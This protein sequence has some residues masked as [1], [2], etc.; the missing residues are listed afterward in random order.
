MYSN[1]IL[2]LDL[3]VIIIQKYCEKYLK[4]DKDIDKINKSKTI[5]FVLDQLSDIRKTKDFKVLKYIFTIEKKQKIKDLKDWLNILC[6]NKLGLFSKHFN[7]DVEIDMTKGYRTYVNLLSKL[8]NNKTKVD[9]KEPNK[10]ISILFNLLFYD[11][12]VGGGVEIPKR[13]RKRKK[14]IYTSFKSTQQQQITQQQKKYLKSTSTGKGRWWRIVREQIINP[15]IEE[16]YGTEIARD[17]GMFPHVIN[18]LFEYKVSWLNPEQFRQSLERPSPRPYNKIFPIV[19]QSHI[20]SCW[21]NAILVALMY[22][23]HLKREFAN[24]ITFLLEEGIKELKQVRTQQKIKEASV[25]RIIQTRLYELLVLQ[26]DS[27]STMTEKKCITSDFSFVRDFI[28]ILTA[29][30]PDIFK[31]F[32]QYEKHKANT[33]L[34]KIILEEGGKIIDI[35]NL[36]HILLEYGFKFKLKSIPGHFIQLYEK[37]VHG[38]KITICVESK[39]RGSNYLDYVTNGFEFASIILFNFNRSSASPEVSAMDR[40]SA[41]SEDSAMDRSSASSEDSEMDRSFASSED[42]EMKA[43]SEMLHTDIAA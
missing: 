39:P 10:K 43:M 33:P 4:P 15:R 2:K 23:Y 22:P 40:S 7:L 32:S 41:S 26:Y 35:F 36:I 25:A 12:I 9:L 5:Q 1:T 28:S 16:E 11:V 30:A 18:V 14:K 8:E 31:T 6:V 17:I 34:N 38:K 3:I 24:I 20:G 13:K 21:I 27:N 37:I 19:Q 29:I 42:S